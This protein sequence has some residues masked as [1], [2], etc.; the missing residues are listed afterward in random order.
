MCDLTI[1]ESGTRVFSN[2]NQEC[3]DKGFVLE[4]LFGQVFFLLF[5]CTKVTQL[6]A[7][8]FQPS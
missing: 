2:T 6:V 7:L 5:F 1:F 8:I 3:D 4:L